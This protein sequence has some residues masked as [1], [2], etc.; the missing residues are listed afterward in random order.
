MGILSRFKKKEDNFDN[1]PFLPD[2]KALPPLPPKRG[3]H[4]SQRTNPSLPPLP[5][6]HQ[7]G[8]FKSDNLP[9]LPRFDN[10]ELPPL[11]QMNTPTKLPSLH[12]REEETH[13]PKELDDLPPLDKPINKPIHK[14]VPIHRHTQ[15]HKHVA[16]APSNRKAKVFVQLNKYNDIV[17]TINKMEGKIE[18]LQTSIEQIKDIRAKE[19]QIINGWNSILSEAKSKIEEV[20]RKLPVADD[21]Y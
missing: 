12:M 19:N 16:H 20:N 13:I 5:P 2:D 3:M 11:P 18:N 10:D 1:L 7:Q 9:P 17:D 8:S 21:N 14:H 15:T 4:M 6:R